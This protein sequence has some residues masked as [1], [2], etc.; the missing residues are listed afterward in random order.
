MSLRHMQLELSWTFGGDIHTGTNKHLYVQGP[1]CGLNFSL[2]YFLLMLS[3][4]AH[5]TFL[6]LSFYSCK[7][8]AMVPNSG[9]LCEL[10]S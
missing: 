3:W 5:L 9:L 4:T 8:G 6:G 2:C 1:R 7:K 10:M